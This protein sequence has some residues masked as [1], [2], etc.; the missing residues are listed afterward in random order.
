M[1]GKIGRPRK[2]MI[3]SYMLERVPMGV[4]TA[5]QGRCRAEGRPAR[6]V[7]GQ[8]LEAYGTGAG[9]TESVTAI[10]MPQDSAS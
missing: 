10:S 5:F 4:W 8:F 1:A 2:K 7:L 6:W 3:H 9:V